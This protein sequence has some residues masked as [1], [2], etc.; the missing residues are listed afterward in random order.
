MRTV[1]KN[2]Y[3]LLVP[4]PELDGSLKASNLRLMTGTSDKVLHLP[5][6][7]MSA[8]LGANSVYAFSDRALYACRYGENQFTTYTLPVQITGVLDMLDN[9]TAIVASGA[10]A[11]VISLPQ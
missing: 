6:A 1:G 3:Q 9:N 5:T 8:Y 2:T 10:E 4:S 11:Y 7:C